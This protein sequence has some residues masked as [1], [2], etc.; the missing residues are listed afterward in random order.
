MPEFFANQNMLGVIAF[1]LNVLT[2]RSDDL[3]PFKSWTLSEETLDNATRDAYVAYDQVS[4]L[5]LKF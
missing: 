4:S 1:V 5:N 2:V 3:F